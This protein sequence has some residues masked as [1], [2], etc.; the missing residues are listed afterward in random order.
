MRHDVIR[1]PTS[2]RIWRASPF[3]IGSLSM[4][5]QVNGV[6]GH[7]GWTDI[8]RCSPGKELDVMLTDTH[9]SF[10]DSCVHSFSIVLE[11]ANHRNQRPVCYS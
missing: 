5:E 11:S 8:L 10:V 6:C 4:A 3:A 9:G 7:M 1:R 2:I